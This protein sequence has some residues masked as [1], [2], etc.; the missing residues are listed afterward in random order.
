MLVLELL[1]L[2]LDVDIRGLV[3]FSK[4][5]NQGDRRSLL[6]IK[7][8]RLDGVEYTWLYRSDSLI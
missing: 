7:A 1:K 5:K 2:L 6:F 8:V 3:L 4:T